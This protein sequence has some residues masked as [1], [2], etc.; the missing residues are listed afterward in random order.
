VTPVGPGG[1]GGSAGWVTRMRAVLGRHAN[2]HPWLYGPALR[3]LGALAR[4]GTPA[5]VPAGAV[6]SDEVA[7]DLPV[8]LVVLLGAD[9]EI[10]IQV[11]RTVAE[12][13][14]R[15]GGF[16][17]VFLVDQPVWAALRRFG[18]VVD[19]LVPQAEWERWPASGAWSDYLMHRL[20]DCRRDY[21]ARTTVV[22]PADAAASRDLV[23]AAVGAGS[24]DPSRLTALARRGLR[25]LDV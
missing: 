23:A 14:V 20:R 18:Y 10:A 3:I 2:A 1:R 5:K 11:G 15:V 9:E 21:G 8:T 7:A 16:K 24:W 6:V 22:L 19:H 12:L 13:Q 25:H 4:A 17:P